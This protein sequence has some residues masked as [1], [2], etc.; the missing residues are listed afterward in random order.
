MPPQPKPRWKEEDIFDRTDI[1]VLI[2]FKFSQSQE[3]EIRAALKVAVADADFA[4]FIE[5]VE[6]EIA[7]YRARERIEHNARRPAQVRAALDVLEK[8]ARLLRERLPLLDR[9]TRAILKR[10]FTSLPEKI[11][12]ELFPAPLGPMIPQMCP[13]ATT[14]VDGCKIIV[15][16]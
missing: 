13:F 12:K 4:A 9:E 7:E 8:P 14:P 2:P 6:G 11:S 3:R 16:S 5:A 1:L 15:S 10:N